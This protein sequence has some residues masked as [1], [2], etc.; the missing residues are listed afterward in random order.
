MIKARSILHTSD[1]GILRLSAGRDAGAQANAA[2]LHFQMKRERTI[3]HGKFLRETDDQ[4]SGRD[5]PHSGFDPFG[6]WAG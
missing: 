6:I 4:H 1:R 3:Y 2:H 5:H